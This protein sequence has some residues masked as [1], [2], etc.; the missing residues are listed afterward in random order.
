MSVPPVIE[1]LRQ[2]VPRTEMRQWIRSSLFNWQTRL[3]PEVRRFQGM[4]SRFSLELKESSV[5]LA[6]LPADDPY[7]KEAPKSQSFEEVLG[8]FLQAEL[9]LRPTDESVLWSLAGMA[10]DRCDND[11]GRQ[12]WSPLCVKDPRN[13]RWLVEAALWVF[14]DSGHDT[15]GGLR[16][17][18]EQLE[19]SVRR[20]RSFLRKSVEGMDNGLAEAALIALRIE[21]GGSVLGWRPD[22]SER[23]KEAGP[24][25]P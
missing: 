13:V 17:T 7:W 11:F 5:R 20:F 15:T 4:F 22:I 25:R 19:R 6:E 18:L 21:Y 10:V 24:R 23:W 8:H 1:R 12:Y 3:Y 9:R 2:R 14:H 16:A